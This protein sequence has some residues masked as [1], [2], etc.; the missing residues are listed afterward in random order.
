MMEDTVNIKIKQVTEATQVN[1]EEGVDDL[2]RDEAQEVG[3]DTANEM[4]TFEL[5]S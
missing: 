2:E 3:S 1:E 4:Q 5:R